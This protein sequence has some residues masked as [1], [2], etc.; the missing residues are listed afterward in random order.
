[1]TGGVR[2]PDNSLSG[3][4]LFLMLEA[5]SKPE[6]RDELAAAMRD[7]RVNWARFLADGAAPYLYDCLKRAGLDAGLPADIRDSFQRLLLEQTGR[8]MVMLRELDAA[9]GALNAAGITPVLLKGAAL[10]HEVYK[11]PGHRRLADLDLLVR[12]SETEIAAQAL[13]SIGYKQAGVRGHHLNFA[14]E[15]EFPVMIELHTA[16]F[17]PDNPLY[18]LAFPLDA[19]ELTACA[20]ELETAGGRA[21]SFRREDQFVY[22]ACHAAKDCYGSMKHMVDLH[23]LIT[24][25]TLNWQEI[26][27]ISDR[28]KLSVKIWNT[29]DLFNYYG[30]IDNLPVERRRVRVRKMT[31][32]QQKIGQSSYNKAAGALY[33]IKLIEGSGRRGRALLLLPGYL[34]G[35][36]WSALLCVNSRDDRLRH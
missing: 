11:H 13:S 15:R 3:H 5:P 28:N 6:R 22:L 21:L 1:M 9:V 25:H 32:L 31:E 26:L 12:K 2:G 10:L 23:R 29:V 24:E 33:Y 18:A 7:G 14:A 19:G 20:A 35:R 36:A 17:N 34:A 4:Y 16:L 27:S 8:N 30:I